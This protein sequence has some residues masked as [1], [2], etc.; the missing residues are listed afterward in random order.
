MSDDLTLY[1]HCGY[2]KTGSS[3]LQS[4]LAAN[5]DYLQSHG[6]CYPTHDSDN[7]AARGEPTAGNGHDFALTLRALDR[8]RSS[9]ML[10][11]AIKTADSARANRLLLSAEGFFH[12]FGL[13][14]DSLTLLNDICSELGVKV[15]KLL[16]FVR[17]PAEHALSVYCHRGKGAFLGPPE[18]WL[19]QGYE[20]LDLMKTF[21]SELNRNPGIMCFWRNYSHQDKIA[22]TLFDQW[23]DVPVPT[24]I[25]GG[26]VRESL[27]ISEVLAIQAMEESIPGCGLDIAVALQKLDPECRPKN[28]KLLDN[29][30]RSITYRLKK[31]EVIIER[32]D[33][34]LP[35]NERMADDLKDA[36]RR[37]GDFQQ[38]S[39]A[40]RLSEQQLHAVSS[41]L[42]T[43]FTFYSRMKRGIR[44]LVPPMLIRWIRPRR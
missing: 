37:P 10:K 18:Q 29:M 31:W 42:A 36:W 40:V 22:D 21:L 4:V 38:S 30:T 20:T 24:Y 6:V 16:V 5:R 35:E 44:R 2:H 13:V 43:H 33:S 32:M 8:V 17:D 19:L 14:P 1:L 12:T 28:D 39:R 11:Q 34:L 27:R 26:R 7:R 25:S 23:L 15:I 41:A 9:V 3:Y